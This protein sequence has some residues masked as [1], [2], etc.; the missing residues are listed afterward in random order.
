MS[1]PNPRDLLDRLTD[2]APRLIASG[3]EFHLVTFTPELAQAFLT[4]AN[5]NNRGVRPKKVREL[6]RYIRRG[7][8]RVKG[9]M[10][11]GSNGILVDG[12]HRLRACFDAGAPIQV[13]I[14]IIPH[15]DI[16]KSNQFSD[17]GAP[18]SLCDFLVFN[19]IKEAEDVVGLLRY[20]RCYR[21][22]GGNPFDRGCLIETERN[23]YLDLYNE[24]GKQKIDAAINLVP[25]SLYKGLRPERSFINWL[26]F[27]LLE[28]DDQAAKE[29]LTSVAK[30]VNLPADAPALV[31]HQRL[32]DLAQQAKT[33]HTKAK[34]ITYGVPFI[35]AWNHY[36]RQE[37]ASGISI[38]Y[39]VNEK[40][41]FIAGAV[42][43]SKPKP[44]EE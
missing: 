9:T 25:K 42:S 5:P 44:T 8:W 33:A 15:R 32:L 35:K 28:I 17:I 41:P 34:P 12:Q 39:R 27:Q 23:Q 37:P 4:Y 22:S 21:V 3:Q 2:C 14:H 7:E 43:V 11:I 38:R 16:N 31:L 40:V 6:T 18:R 13:L 36:Y 26:A 20:E 1:N 29:F 10:E 30:P 19:G 24:I